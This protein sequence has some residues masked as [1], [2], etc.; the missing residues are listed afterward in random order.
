MQASGQKDLGARLASKSDLT[1][2][3]ID[4]IARSATPFKL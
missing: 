3:K 1:C 2:A 4:L